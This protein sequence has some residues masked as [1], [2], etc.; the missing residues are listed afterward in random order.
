MID[1]SLNIPE[2]DINQNAQICDAMVNM[3]KRNFQSKT[4]LFNPVLFIIW[5]FRFYNVFQQIVGYY[6]FLFTFVRRNDE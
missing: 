5:I 1:A 6:L 3:I 2:P 4:I